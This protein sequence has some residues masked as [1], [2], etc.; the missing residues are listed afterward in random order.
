MDSGVGTIGL[1]AQFS[2]VSN[3][4]F[5]ELLSVATHEWRQEEHK[6]KAYLTYKDSS[7]LAWE[8]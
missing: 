7:N 2:I 4:N 3:M 8:T 1:S 5:V 6:F